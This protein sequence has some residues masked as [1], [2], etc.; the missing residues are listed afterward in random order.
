MLQWCCYGILDVYGG[1]VAVKVVSKVSRNASKGEVALADPE[2][3]LSSAFP[4]SKR[5]VLYF[6]QFNSPI[7]KT[8]FMMKY[9]ILKLCVYTP[10]CMET[11]IINLNYGKMFI[12]KLCMSE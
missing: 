2:E 7:G 4:P 11:G 9:S 1:T 8:T 6:H 3:E 12:V 10:N 5:L